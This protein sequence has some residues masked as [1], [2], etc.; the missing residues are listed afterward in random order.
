MKHGI[1]AVALMACLTAHAGVDVQAQLTSLKVE[2]KDLD[3]SDEIS[4]T[5]LPTGW[6]YA[7]GSFGTTTM[8]LEEYGSIAFQDFRSIERSQTV[9]P[10]FAGVQFSGSN[11]DALATGSHISS[12]VDATV[13]LEVTQASAST[14]WSAYYW[15]SAKTELKVTAAASIDIDSAVVVDPFHVNVVQGSSTLRFWGATGGYDRLTYASGGDLGTFSFHD[16]KMLQLTF[17]NTYWDSQLV[18]VELVTS[19]YQVTLPTSPVPEP[20]AVWLLL[21]G[22]PIIR[23]LGRRPSWTAER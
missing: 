11:A 10:M 12:A 6:T 14:T 22:V 7:S 15:L 2:L 5:F 23:F 16:T 21:V 18:K 19:A 1:A 4:P 3:T 20:S 17:S 8:G 9:A 13:G